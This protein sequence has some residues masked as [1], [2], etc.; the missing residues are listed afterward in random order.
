MISRSFASAV[1]AVLDP[2]AVDVL[3]TFGYVP[4]QA[5]ALP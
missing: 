4:A 5:A 2:P 3:G 1:A